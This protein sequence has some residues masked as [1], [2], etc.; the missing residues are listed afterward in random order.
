MGAF[1]TYLQQEKIKHLFIYPRC[2]KINSFV[3]RSNRSLQEEFIN[4]HLEYA[5]EDISEFNT[6]LMKHLIWYNTKR[7]HKGLNNQSPID[8]LLSVSPECQ[9]YVTYTTN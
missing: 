5:V 6:L 7:V 3:E 9:K 8:Y 2:P 1:S 4:H